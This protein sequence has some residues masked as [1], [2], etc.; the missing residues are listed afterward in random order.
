MDDDVGEKGTRLEKR[1]NIRNTLAKLGLDQTL[2]AVV[3]VVAFLAGVRLLRGAAP[4]ESWLAVKE[5]PS[6]PSPPLPPSLSSLFVLEIGIS[7]EMS[8]VRRRRSC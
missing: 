4:A 5:V 6:F 1:L 2:G 3:N 7:R 8:C